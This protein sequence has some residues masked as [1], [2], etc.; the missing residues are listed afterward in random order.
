MIGAKLAGI[1]GAVL[2]VPIVLVCQ[3]LIN[4]LIIKPPQEIEQSKKVTKN[5]SKE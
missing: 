4:E 2:S 3:V 1:T 5:P